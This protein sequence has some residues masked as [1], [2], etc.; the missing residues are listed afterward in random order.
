VFSEEFIQFKI[1]KAKNNKNFGESK[2]DA[3]WVIKYLHS[4]SFG[5]SFKMFRGKIAASPNYRSN[6]LTAFGSQFTSRST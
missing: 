2:V 1:T 6:K 5:T 3:Q 4:P